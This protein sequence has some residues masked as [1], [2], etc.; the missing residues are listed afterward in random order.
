[1]ILAEMPVWV[2][3]KHLLSRLRRLDSSHFFIH[4]SKTGQKKVYEI[5]HKV[6]FDSFAGRIVI[7]LYRQDV[8]RTLENFR[9]LHRY[10]GFVFLFLW[11]EDK[12]L[13]EKCLHYKV[14]P[15][16]CIISGCVIQGGNTFPH[17]NF[18]IKHSHAG[19][20][21]MVNSEADSTNSQFLFM[22]VK[23]SWL[24][25]EHVVSGKVALHPIE[26]GAGTYSGKPRKK[27]FIADCCKIPKRKCDK[28]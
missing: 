4:Q 1:M 3:P 2:H 24:D 8:L 22:T 9:A 6:Y 10:L 28:E 12:G 25:T 27:I 18:R 11:E 23:A 19:V 7:G 16:H 15:L 13:S 26:G 14:T 21:S 5:T 17:E 20:V